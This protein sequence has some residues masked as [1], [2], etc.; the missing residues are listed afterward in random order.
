MKKDHIPEVIR[1]MEP[2]RLCGNVYFVGTSAVSV[3]VIDTGDGLMM[4]DTGYPFMRDAILENMKQLHLD[5]ADLRYIIHS[6]GHY[7]HYGNTAYLKQLSG[8]KTCI[9]RIDNEIVNGTRDLSWAV[10]LK[11]D[12]IPPFDCDV[13]LED[14][15][16]LTLGNTTV[17]FRRAPGHTEGTMCLFFEIED[18]GRKLRA[19]MHGGLGLG[20]MKKAFLERYGLGFDMRKQFRAD[21]EKLRELPVDVVLGNHPDQNHTQERYERLKQG[22]RD[23]FIDASEWKRMLESSMKGFDQMTESEETGE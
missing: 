17:H 22:D 1:D 2:F 20:S 11:F 21:L 15:D 14:G 16:E 12:R 9:S 18:A 23:A 10:E 4:I 7:D 3:H 13:L 19:A 8:A 6:H 5:P